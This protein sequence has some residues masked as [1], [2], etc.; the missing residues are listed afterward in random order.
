LKSPKSTGPNRKTRRQAERNVNTFGIEIEF[1]PLNDKQEEFVKAYRDGYNIFGY[2]SAGTGKS[3]LAC[4]L[5]LEEVLTNRTKKGI[6][7]KKIVIVRSTVSVRDQGFL[8]GSV[9]E[10][11]EPF[12]APY[13]KIFNDITGRGTGFE[14]LMKHGVIE[15]ISTS[16]VRGATF[17][18]TIL[19]LDEIQNYNWQECVSAMTRVGLETRV[20]VCGDGKQ[21]DLHYKKND[22]SGWQNLLAVT[23]RMN[24]QF[25]HIMFTRDDIV[26]SGF[27]KDFI[28]ACED[29]SL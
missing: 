1:E 10:K 24:G 25:A 19:I 16:F 8:P 2:G 4:Y 7:P 18:D 26:R 12:M 22:V 14:E 17:D 13:R 15:F 9:A 3:F 5:A 21:D 23:Q 29:L 11:E 6:G 28:I 27:C 20:I